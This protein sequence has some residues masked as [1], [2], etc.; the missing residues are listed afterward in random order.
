[1]LLESGQDVVDLQVRGLDG[2]PEPVHT[3][4]QLSQLPLDGLE[5]HSLL[6]SNAV[7]LLVDEPHEFADVSLGEDMLA[8][9]LDDETLEVLRVEPRRVAAPPAAL[10]EGLADVVGVAAALGLGRCER[11]T[12]RLALGQP[13]EQ[14]RAGRAAGMDPGRRLGLQHP[15]HSP[16]LL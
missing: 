11:P 16:E 4:A 10:D 8:K 3:P 12:A 5:L 14:V 1:M 2:V 6:A 9:L 13:A 15:L 7:H